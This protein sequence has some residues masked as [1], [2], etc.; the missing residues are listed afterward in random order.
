MA[1]FLLLSL[2]ASIVVLGQEHCRDK[3]CS[4]C[5]NGYWGDKC[6]KYCPQPC[7]GVCSQSCHKDTG[8]CYYCSNQGNWGTRCQYECDNRCQMVDD[9][10]CSLSVL[11][12]VSNGHCF[13]CEDGSWGIHCQHQCNCTSCDIE[14]GECPKH[15][16]PKVDGWMLIAYVF[17]GVLG[18]IVVSL[19]VCGALGMCF[20]GCGV[21][22]INFR[23]D[24]LNRQ[25]SYTTSTGNAGY[26]TINGY[27]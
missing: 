25:V 6:Q 7:D 15:K 21:N 14:T 4:Q 19:L 3:N 10:H 5:Q 12:N 27:S 11:C 17:F 18:L 2:V 16:P 24:R 13:K 9:G 1:F 26:A 23:F 8:D 22:P 20:P